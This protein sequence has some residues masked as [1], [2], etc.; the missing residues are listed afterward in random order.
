MK[1]NISNNGGLQSFSFNVAFTV[2]DLDK[3]INWYSEVFGFKLISRSTF[4][5]PAGDAEAAII[6]GNGLKLELLHV[7]FG[8]RIE[9]I[10]AAPPAHLVPIGNKSIV[11]Q[12][13]NLALASK[14]LEAKGVE[15]VW[16]EQN[17]VKG[18]MLCSMIK[19]VDGNKINIFQTNTPF[20]TKTQ[21]TP[22]PDASVII[23]SHINIWSEYHSQKR[24]ELIDKTYAT[25][26]R[27]TD[28]NGLIV[29][30]KALNEFIDK[31]LAKYPRY[32][33]Y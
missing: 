16:R 32:T 4:K 18:G 28:P 24:K 12:V 25:D 8:Q 3:S 22:T 1:D 2:A 31:L 23:T 27:L 7:P 5:I 15:F 14:E 6:E 29:G 21:P 26:F 10:F 17:L 20:G 9:E 33:Y 30:R 13:D 11:F 19:D